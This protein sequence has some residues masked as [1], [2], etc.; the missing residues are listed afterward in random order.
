MQRGHAYR[1]KKDFDRAIADFST[2]L[3]L[4]PD[5][6]QVYLERGFAYK[7]KGDK[8]KAR[9]DFKK[10]LDSTTEPKMREGIEDEIRRLDE[11]QS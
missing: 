3:R 8:E 7:D 6:T 10:F 11:G 4:M 9:A 1:D 5:R 2:A